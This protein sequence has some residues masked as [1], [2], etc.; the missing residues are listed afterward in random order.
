MFLQQLISKVMESPPALFY[1]NGE[2]HQNTSKVYLNIRNALLNANHSIQPVGIR[3]PKEPEYFLCILACIELGIPYVPLKEDFPESRIKEISEDA[4]INLF[5]DQ[6][7][8]DSLSEDQ[9]VTED[10]CNRKLSD[11][12]PLYIIFTSGSTGRPKGVVISRGAFSSYLN[13]LDQ[14]LPEINDEDRL[15]QVTEFTF[16]ISL[17]DLVLFLTKKPSIYFTDFGGAIFKMAQ[18]IAKYKIT[19]VNTVPNN[20]NML[21]SDFIA[22]KADFTSLRCVMIGGARLSY[23]L[24]KKLCQYFSDKAVSNFYGPTE[25]TIYSHA[26]KI[27]FNE[28]EDCKDS[29]VSIG[30]PNAEVHAEIFSGS[31][32]CNAGESGELLLSGK[33][34]MSLYINNPEK[35][36]EVII[37]IAGVD[38]YKTG[39]LAYK[40][41]SNEFFITGR[42]DDTI[43]YRGYRINLLDI[44]S[45]ITKLPYVEDVTTIAIADEIKENITV[46]FIILK[47]NIDEKISVSRIKQ[48]LKEVIV[49]YQIPE[50]IRF[51]EKFP[52]NISGKVCRK[53]LLEEYNK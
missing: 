10:I 20:I 46:S 33:Q 25:F 30:V 14:Y 31:Q 44:D 3:L 22:S 32:F 26:K 24:Y 35:T 29:N 38:Y 45:Y 49:D 28:L 11:D 40:N 7:F 39:D 17:I 18:E 43:K 5:I 9:S 13:W 50:K 8:I 37:N 42:L 51:T 36:S 52:I 23:G 21:L 2:Q 47:I 19:T 15:L 12:M 4:E 34:I 27:K 16:D 1:S 48:D 41:E 6:E 53:Q